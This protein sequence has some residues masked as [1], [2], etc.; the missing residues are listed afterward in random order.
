MKYFLN[1]KI[2]IRAIL[3]N[4]GLLLHV[5]IFMYLIT[6]FI[7]LIFKEYY[8]ILP[9]L[10]VLIFNLIL[11]QLLYRYF[12]EDIKIHLWDIIISIAIS[13]FLA[14]LFGAFI[15]YMVS[16]FSNIENES[17]L[18]LK[19]FINSLFES[20]SGFTST[21][22]SMIKLPS[23][24]PKTLQ[25]FRSLE[26][27][28]GGVGLIIFVLSLIEPKEE[29]YQLFL[30]E[31]KT[32]S[33][34]KNIIST[35]R[36][37]ALIYVV[38]TVLAFLLFVFYKMPIWQAVNHSMCCIATGGFTITDDSFSSYNRPIKVIAMI[39]MVFGSISFSI[40]YRMLFKKKVFEFFKNIQ[41]RVF[42]ILLILGSIIIA[43]LNLNKITVLNSFFQF[44]SSLATCGFHSD[45]ITLYQSST[46]LLLIFAMFVGGCSGST[47]GGIKIRRLIFLFQSIIQRIKSFTL[48]KEKKVLKRENIKSEPSSINIEESE[49]TNRLYEAS[50]LFFLWTLTLFIGS[51][52][53]LFCEKDL[54]LVNVIFD[55]MSA[56]SNVGLSTGVIDAS[57]C[58]F[59]K[60]V[61]IFIMWIGRI[62]IIPV[63]ILFLSFFL[64]KSK[65]RCKK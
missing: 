30:I 5:P 46:K 31:T 13:W 37:I 51:L 17:I 19:S 59:T 44:F 9:I 49:K 60:V 33:F 65:K 52:L 56:L 55:V 22:L 26:Q 50:V 42:I 16:H 23:I 48:K 36:I 27:W 12:F 7:S 63:I 2:N 3:G 14:P 39:I 58:F 45:E 35:I 43:A 62:E 29:D 1:Q 21:G 15:F 18:S 25:F 20:F 34:A 32:Y 64:K 61:F 40:H 54:S 38:Y 47:V 28:V 4:I 11:A 6:I 8:A 41:S 53:T 57:I 24:L 10:S